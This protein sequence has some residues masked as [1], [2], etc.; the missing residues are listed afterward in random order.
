MTNL[1]NQTMQM[2]LY[3]DMLRIRLIE[4]EIAIRYV[5]QE[6]RC[7]VHL[8]VGQEA[9]AVGACAA[10]RLEDRVFS[11]HRCHG[12]YLAK[13]GD[14]VAMLSEIYG[15]EPGCAGGRGG[16]MHLS[17]D[18]VNMHLSIPIIGSSLPLALGAALSDSLK[19]NG[20]VTL[21]F[22]GDA[23]VEEGVFHE[24]ANFAALRRLPIVFVCENNYFSVYS[25][26]AERQPARPL[27]NVGLAH[28]LHTAGGDGNDVL[29]VHRDVSAAV[30]RA[31]N[32]DG[33]A[34]LCFDTFRWREHCGPNYDDDLEYRTGYDIEDWKKR[35]PVAAQERRLLESGTMSQDDIAV[36]RRELTEEIDAAFETARKAPLPDASKASL[37]VY[38]GVA[39]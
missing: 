27:L 20:R 9:V 11:T 30:E 31:R 32:G 37:H 16:S 28:G 1:P 25:D 12:H 36:L 38:A 35:C 10:L 4:E 13:G 33:P 6:M 19:N 21:A 23:G 2:T 29:A 26:I 18:A 5:E 17:D 22:L 3:R 34:F 24:C 8:S 7:P 39:S 15:R 14:L